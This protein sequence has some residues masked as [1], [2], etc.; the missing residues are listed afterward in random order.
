MISLPLYY[1]MTDTDVD[2]VIHAV[3]RI[4]EYYG[5]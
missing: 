4:A 3:V 1:G 5:K 2:D